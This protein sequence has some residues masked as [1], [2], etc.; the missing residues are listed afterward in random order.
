AKKLN[1]HGYIKHLKNGETSV[2][3]S[4]PVDS[5]NRF[6][7]II[8]NKA[9]KRAKILKVVE[10]TRKKPVKIGFEIISSEEVQQQNVVRKDG[11]YPVRLV[12]VPVKKKSKKKKNNIT[13]KEAQAI[14]NEYNTLKEEKEFYKKKY[15]DIKNSNTWRVTEPIR[16]IGKVLK[17]SEKKEIH[18][19]S[20]KINLIPFWFQVYFIMNQN[21]NVYN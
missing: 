14:I 8:K 7:G 13:P 20:F 16:H 18:L 17:R 2:V 19:N 12:E 1:L 11:Y 21:E 10:K 6:R 3:V 15:D 4:G 5:I 9:P